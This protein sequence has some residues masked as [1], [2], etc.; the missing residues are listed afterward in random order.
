MRERVQLVKLPIIMEE[1]FEMAPLEPSPPVMFFEKAN[2]LKDWILQLDQE[3]EKFKACLHKSTFEKNQLKW[4]LEQQESKFK[5]LKEK[6]DKKKDKA[7]R[8]KTFLNQVDSLLRSLHEQLEKAQIEDGKWVNLYN[9]VIKQ[10]SELRKGLEGRIQE[11]TQLLK[12][13]QLQ[14]DKEA[15]LKEDALQRHHSN[16]SKIKKMKEE[17]DSLRG[18]RQ[19]HEKLVSDSIYWSREFT[20]LKDAAQDAKAYAREME[21]HTTTWNE[22]LTKMM[23]YTN[24]FIGEFSRRVQEVFRDMTLENM[25]LIVFH[26]VLF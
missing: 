15:H 26:F 1:Y 8:Y 19:E 18:L 22:H 13:S 12:D 24:E 25:H 16:P 9:Q 2:Y 3:K 17:I 21:Q 23:D 7:K 10:N 5:A 4:D 20:V 6:Y 11:L 14:G